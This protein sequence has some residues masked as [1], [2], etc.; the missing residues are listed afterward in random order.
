M[1]LS[2]CVDRVGSSCDSAAVTNLGV[3]QKVTGS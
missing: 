3:G 1:L 2:F